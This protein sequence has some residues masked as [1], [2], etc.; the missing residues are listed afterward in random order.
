MIGR[1]KSK[2]QFVRKLMLRSTSV[3]VNIYDG[4]K[5]KG[6]FGAG[7]GF[8]RTQRGD[9]FNS[10]TDE[11]EDGFY[12]KSAKRKEVDD[13]IELIGVP[14]E[15]VYSMP[16]SKTKSDVDEPI[17]VPANIE[18][19]SA[20]K[21]VKPGDRILITA[22]GVVQLNR[23]GLSCGPD[24]VNTQDTN[25]IIPDRPTGALIAAL[26]GPDDLIFIGSR[27]E[28]V[29][30]RRGLILLRIN[31]GDFSDNSGSYKVTVKISRGK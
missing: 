10:K 27:I 20:G 16:K 13:F 22:T 30:T 5:F 8:F 2:F 1:R 26:G 14:R 15:L 17:D 24:G 28:F 6:H 23:S 3:V 31:D 21:F 4:D 18:W 9:G 25:K 19:T 29:A 12:S 11:S 7:K